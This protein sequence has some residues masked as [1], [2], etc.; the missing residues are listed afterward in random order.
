ME[1][2][3]D[4]ATMTSEECSAKSA[5]GADVAEKPAPQAVVIV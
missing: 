4:A 2:A 5:E 3:V 1:V